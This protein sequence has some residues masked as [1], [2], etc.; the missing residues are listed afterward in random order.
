MDNK[1]LLLCA[2]YSVAPN[3]FGYCGPDKNKSL[4][5]HLKENIADSEVTHI[6]KEFETL[7]SYL[8]LIAYANKI[9]DPFDERVVE[10]YWLGNS[11]LKNVSTIY[12]SFLKEKLL[13]D[14]KI[15]YKIFSLPVIPHHSFHVF[16]IFKRTGNINSNH[17]LETMDECRISWGQVIKY[18]ISKIKYLIITTRNLIIN[19]N[20]LSL[21]KILINKKIEIDYKGK[22]FI[23]NLK[24]GDWVSFHWGMVCGKLTERQVKNLEFYTQKAIDFYNL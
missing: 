20:K 1:G 24:P 22:S 14:K 5:D 10:A 15:N 9:K 16:N 21:G 8:Q 23:K 3:Y 7:Y 2:R 11:F 6:L 4:I 12:P 18:Q 17:T 13:L 19:N